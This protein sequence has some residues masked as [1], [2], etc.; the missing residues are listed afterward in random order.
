ERRNMKSK[1]EGELSSLKK[2]IEDMNTQ[3]VQIESKLGEE[4]KITNAISKL[5]RIRE[6]LGEKR[7]QSYIIMA[8]KQVIENNLNDI[9]SKFDLSIRNAEIEISPKRG[10]SN[11][12][13]YIIV[14]TN[15]GDQLPVTSLS[16]G[17]KKALAL[18][19]RL[20]IARSLMSDANFFI[21]D[22]PTV[23]LDEDRRNYLIEIIKNLKEV[24]PQIIVVT[25]DREIENAA[26]YVINVEKKG[27]KSVVSEANDN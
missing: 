16:G 9:I 7:L 10:K 17:E 2:E 24:V 4:T 18:G 21:L 5:T 1:I 27:N 25:H 23:H 15:S 6:A 22:E 12:G 19:L 3:M 20:A 26:D 13:D 8:T 14:Y 11:R